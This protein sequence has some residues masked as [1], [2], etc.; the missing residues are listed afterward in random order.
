[1]VSKVQ[2]PKNPSHQNPPNYDKALEFM[3][4]QPNK[5]NIDIAALINQLD[6]KGLQSTANNLQQKRTEIESMVSS[7]NPYTE[8][9]TIDMISNYTIILDDLNNKAHSTNKEALQKLLAATFS[10]GFAIG[11]GTDIAKTLPLMA[12]A[13]AQSDL[14]IKILNH[15]LKQKKNTRK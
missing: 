1:M 13:G 5:D 15:Y 4:E 7:M 9:E 2:N 3:S 8:Q 10:V 14:G 12:I 11:Q 6:D